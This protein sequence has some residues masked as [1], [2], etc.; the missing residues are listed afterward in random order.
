MI[1]QIYSKEENPEA[2][3]AWQCVCDTHVNIFLTGK[4]G[5]GKT[6]FLKNLRAHCPK[7]MVV[8]APTGV[9]A[10]NAGGV[11]IHSFFQLP[12]SPYIPGTKMGKDFSMRK[13][14]IK[15]LR[16][17]DL[18]VIDEISMV[19]AD[20]LDSLDMVL[21]KYRRSS[22]PF[23]GVQLLMI[24][25]LQQLAPVVTDDVRDMLMSHYDNLY[26]FGSKALADTMYATIELKKIYRQNE[27]YFVDMLNQVRNNQISTSLLE[28]LN[29]RY[30]EGFNPS[31]KE[32]Y[33][34]LTTHNNKADKI[35]TEKLSLLKGKEMKYV[36]TVDGTFPETSYPA[37]KELKLKEG[38]QVMFLKNDTQP[39]KRYY[40]GKIGKV[41][42]MSKD[43]VLVDCEGETVE[44]LPEKWSNTRY[45]LDKTT[46]E[47][48]E[49]EDGSFTQIPLR[50]AWAI[51][52]HKSQGLTFDKAIIDAQ[53]SFSHGQVYVAL[54]RCRSLEGVVLDSKL[55]YRSFVNDS[56]VVAF[57]DEQRHRTMTDS[58]VEQM[59]QEYALLLITEL[60]SFTSITSECYKMIRLLEEHLHRLFPK[61][62][63]SLQQKMVDVENSI[64]A[65]GDRFCQFSES[66]LK[67]GVDIRNDREYN[68]RLKNGAKYYV[69]KLLSYIKPIIDETH[70]SMDNKELKIR[71]D[72]YREMLDNEYKIK[73]KLFE[74]VSR[75]GFAVDGYIKART[76]AILQADN[77]ADKVVKKSAGKH[78][79]RNEVEHPQLYDIIQSWTRDYADDNDIAETYKVMRT[80]S[81]KMICEKL[82]TTIK[83]LKEI[84]GIGAKKIAMFGKDV[85][86]IVRDYCD[87]NGIVY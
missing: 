18:L 34:R 45:V 44:V 19:R 5:T 38:A 32:G 73:L 36:C 33:I 14:K 17:L 50:L 4:A 69:T 6:T 67:A 28:A 15:I 39:I 65:V 66:Q 1:E 9:A 43:M 57:I 70:I 87:E 64:V 16:T 61:L 54:S 41:L 59:R 24:G 3:L 62:I 86:Q 22:R 51:T 75:D 49:I 21:R 13:E 76:E 25:D 83:A 12:F 10:I 2:Y 26:F 71:F 46:N 27:K 63:D 79:N 37:D 72:G 55:S 80:D 85:V 40:N 20:L 52:I 68:E 11:T 78:S 58:N 84:K 53:M 23:G 35:N 30:I 42:S 8:V 31:D 56:S 47:I 29:S 74:V 60:F 7:R 82:P 81:I 77:N 48:S